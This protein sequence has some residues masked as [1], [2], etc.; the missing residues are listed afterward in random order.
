MKSF[1]STI[2]GTGADIECISV[3]LP[4][5]L[6]RTYTYGV[7]V[8]LLA[9]YSLEVGDFVLVPLGTREVTGVIWDDH[10]DKIP[11]AKLKH[12]LAKLEIPRMSE[13]TRRFAKWVANYNMVS[14]GS[15][16][17]MLISVPDALRPPKPIT[18]YSLAMERPEIR[19]TEARVRVMKVLGVSGPLSANV[20]TKKAGVGAGV[21]KGLI[22]IGALKVTNLLPPPNF[23]EPA[24][25]TL[26]PTLSLEQA[27]VANQIRASCKSRLIIINDGM[28]QPL[29]CSKFVQLFARV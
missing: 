22:K 29:K 25:R 12:V 2:D 7:S 26:G 11:L 15:I 16:L 10:V 8:G 28:K 9:E 4:L 3:L 5:P 23:K 1:R 14:L 21:I 20:L 13:T 6:G 17:R 19:M 18:V 27:S 24:W